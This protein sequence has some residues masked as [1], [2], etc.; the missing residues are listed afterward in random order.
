MVLIIDKLGSQAKVTELDLSICGKHD[1]EGFEVPVDLVVLVHVE[2]GGE[3]LLEDVDD[4]FFGKLT[5]NGLEHG[6]QVT[7]IHPFHDQVEFVH[8]LLVPL[9]RFV[10]SNDIF[11]ALACH[12]L[13]CNLSE[14]VLQVS[15]VT[16]SNL[17]HGKVF[18]EFNVLNQVDSAEAALA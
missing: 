2:Q 8:A 14:R 11:M 1:V 18:F 10:Y 12:I 5:R 6:A 9:V 17:F 16:G 15:I 4:D 13:E 3:D 7:C